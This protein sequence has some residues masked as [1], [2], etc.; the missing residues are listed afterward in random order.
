MNKGVVVNG[1]FQTRQV[2]GVERYAHEVSRRI[3]PDARLVI[4]GRLYAGIRGHFWEQLILPRLIDKAEILWSP[5]NTG[6]LN[7]SN[8]VLSLHDLSVIDHPEWF[9]Q[10][11]ALWHRFLLPRLIKSVK[12]IITMS[13]FT[14]NRIMEYF[15]LQPEMIHCIPEGVDPHHFHLQ[16]EVE[17]LRIRRRYG[18]NGD[19]LLL[20]A[21]LEPRK[22]IER[23]LVAWKKISSEL[24]DRTLV[25]AGGKYRVF[26]EIDTS[27]HVD[28]VRWLGYVDEQDLPG[29]YSAAQAYIL[30]SLYEGFGLSVLEAM[31][32]GTPV[33]A[34]KSGAL[35]EV[36]AESALF[37][38]PYSV[39]SIAQAIVSILCDP[40]LRRELKERGLE[41][42]SLFSWDRTAQEVWLVL[43]RAAA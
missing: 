31:A 41:R 3:Q 22:N 1:R 26:K 17:T 34:A 25:I 27:Q 13:N 14:K 15:G 18:L 37:F 33:V 29:L 42:S 24:K 32:C 5:A 16:P 21:S 12:A 2:T 19:F 40:L 43:E 4:P 11:Y 9:R 35:P 20:V 6:P 10:E 30:P 7:F 38:D 39:D 23:L 28:N 36:T 8:Q